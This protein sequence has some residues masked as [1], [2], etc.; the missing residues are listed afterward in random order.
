M[1]GTIGSGKC[2]KLIGQHI[3]M[4]AKGNDDPHFFK[5][6]PQVLFW[7]SLFFHFKRLLK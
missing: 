3:P 7:I 6:K 2:C 1:L 5:G 4:G